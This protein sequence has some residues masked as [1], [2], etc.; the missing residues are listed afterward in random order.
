M[1]SHTYIM[2]QCT[3][4]NSIKRMYVY[5]LLVPTSMISGI[6]VHVNW[7]KARQKRVLV[8]R[9]RHNNQPPSTAC[10]AG[11]KEPIEIVSRD[12]TMDIL[13]IGSRPLPPQNSCWWLS[14]IAKHSCF[15]NC[16]LIDG[17][18]PIP[19]TEFPSPI[20]AKKK[21]GKQNPIKDMAFV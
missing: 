2:Y 20:K 18:R 14:C 12:R 19:S 17:C 15:G 5:C 3:N 9:T 1:Y 6:W 7:T 8:D 4:N 21:K 11:Q 10:T 16:R 13:Q